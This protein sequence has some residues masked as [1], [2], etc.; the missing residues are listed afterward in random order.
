MHIHNNTITAHTLPLLHYQ[1]YQHTTT[2]TVCPF[3]PPPPQAKEK[4]WAKY[5]EGRGENHALNEKG[6]IINKAAILRE[7]KAEWRKEAE[8]R[9]EITFRRAGQ[10]EIMK[11]AVLLLGVFLSL[12]WYLSATDAQKEE[13]ARQTE[14]AARSGSAKGKAKCA[15]VVAAAGSGGSGIN[16][17][18]ED[19][20]E[21]ERGEEEDGLLG[22][23]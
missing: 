11:A 3:R 1:H 10:D 8:L 18:G 16:P 23:V 20:D 5:N 7:K 13:Q 14:L 2:P 17:F 4:V 15:A 22:S 9:N 19:E 21:D 12:C 6:E